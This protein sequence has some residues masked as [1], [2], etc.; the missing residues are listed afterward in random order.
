MTKNRQHVCSK[1]TMGSLWLRVVA[2]NETGIV[3][4]MLT[5]VYHSILRQNANRFYSRCISANTSF[6][7]NVNVKS[8][9]YQEISTEIKH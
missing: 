8:L 1:I 3:R 7:R 6:P 2:V 5:A 9:A 4:N